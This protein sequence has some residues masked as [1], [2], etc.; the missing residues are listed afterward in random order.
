MKIVVTVMVRDEADI[1]AAMVE[2]HLAQGV[3]LMI[4]TDNGS[5]DGTREILADYAATGRVELHDDPVHEKQQSS[6]VTAMARRAYTEHGADWVINAD[7]D[8]FWLPVDRSL[9]LRTALEQIPVDLVTWPVPVVNMTGVAAHRGT[10]IRRLTYRDLRSDESLMEKAGLH[11]QPTADAIHVGS[12]DVEVVQGNHFVNLESTGRPA[13]ELELEVLHLPW[14]SYEQ[15]SRKVEATGLAYEA[16][17]DKRPSPNHH[18]MRDY[19]RLRA[20]NLYE[21]YAFRHPLVG[22]QGADVGPDFAHDPILVELLESIDPVVPR[23]LAAAL[24][25]STDG[26]VTPEEHLAGTELAR[27]L[28]PVEIERVEAV[29]KLTLEN[30]ALVAR[31]RDA[32]RKLTKSRAAHKKAVAAQAQAQASRP[33]S[34]SRLVGVLRDPRRLFRAVRRRLG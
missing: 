10:G 14:R 27:R 8:E 1:I 34:G 9:T 22:E 3:D 16:S 5:V 28:L 13:P 18:G 33:R 2:H 21:F 23:H 11:A 29:T 7:A 31:M 19:R 24:S 15:Y 25:S 12:P 6:V 4:V 20:G 17:P 32:E 30:R 26:D